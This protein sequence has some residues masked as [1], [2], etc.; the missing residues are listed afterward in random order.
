MPRLVFTSELKPSAGISV[1][2]E[3]KNGSNIELDSTRSKA[4]ISV[5]E[6]RHIEIPQTSAPAY[7]HKLFGFARTATAKEGDNHN[8]DSVRS[9]V[10]QSSSENS[11]VSSSTKERKKASLFSNSSLPFQSVT[12]RA[13]GSSTSSR[14]GTLDAKIGELRQKATERQGQKAEISEVAK[15]GETSSGNQIMM[16]TAPESMH[17]A[18]RPSPPLSAGLE[19]RYRSTGS[20]FYD[21]DVGRFGKRNIAVIKP[22]QSVLDGREKKTP[23]STCPP[24][25]RHTKRYSPELYSKSKVDSA[26]H[27]REVRSA[28]PTPHTPFVSTNVL[29]NNDEHSWNVRWC[30]PERSPNRRPRG[31]K[32]TTILTLRGPSSHTVTFE[33]SGLLNVISVTARS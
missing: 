5:G 10:K 27:D 20:P 28:S 2:K 30:S 18:E 21:S 9:I 24:K 16:Q 11:L 15:Q 7:S 22:N 13:R 4:A 12:S 32:A 26:M 33:V 6:V 8:S 17:F 1:G 14:T 23:G 3:K 31:S 25:K 19:A 29:I